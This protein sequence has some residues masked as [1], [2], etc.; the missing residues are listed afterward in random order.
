MRSIVDRVISQKD[1]RG[2][3]SDLRC[4]LVKGKEHRSWP[5]LHRLG[6]S[7]SEDSS[8]KFEA[9]VVG[10]FA[11]HPEVSN[12]GNFGQT[13]NSIW[14][15]RDS[16]TSEDK[17]SPTERRFQHLLAA[18]RNEIGDR[19]IR[20]VQMAKANGIPINYDQ[21]LKDLRYWGPKIRRK[22][23]DSFWSIKSDDSSSDEEK[24]S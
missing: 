11:T 5:A 3:M 16:N 24:I 23:A 8:C 2:L 7:L 14:K 17:V 18:E 13:C 6:I 21:L 19:I 10:L 20:F 15:K 12:H 4:A 9:L 1:N 22:W